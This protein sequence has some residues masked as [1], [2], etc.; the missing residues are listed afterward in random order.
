MRVSTDDACASSGGREPRRAGRE[1]LLEAVFRPVA[2]LLVPFLRWT[3]VSPPTVVLANAAT[4]LV[5]AVALARGDHLVAAALLQAKTLLDNADG[6]LARATGRVTLL[7]RYLDTLADLVVNAALFAALGQVT[8]QWPLAIAAFVALTLVLAADF[9]VS[10]LHRAANG[11][12]SARPVATGRRLER[13]LAAVYGALLGPLDR[14]ARSLAARL[15]RGTSY[16]A[17]TVTALANMGLTTQ[18]VALGVCLVL[19]A[20]SAYL[21]FC[22]ACLAALVPLQLRA[23]RRARAAG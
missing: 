21:W 6:E 22:L 11:S 19:G 4:G 12:A 8:G 3:R 13:S 5:A 15:P 17:V 20:P 23:E 10:E 9:N 1:L 2:R 14:A 16:D 7:G 18:L